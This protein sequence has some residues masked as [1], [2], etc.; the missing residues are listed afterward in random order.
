MTAVRVLSAYQQGDTVAATVQLDG[1]LTLTGVTLTDSA[2]SG[3]MVA[4]P[5]RRLSGR[6]LL[7]WSDA[8]AAEVAAA[9]LAALPGQTVAVAD[10]EALPF[11]EPEPP[12]PACGGDWLKCGCDPDV[13]DAAYQEPAA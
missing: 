11:A 10:D 6:P 12:C 2:Y 1:A 3:R 9:I 5:P 8:V 13:A 7:T 4:R